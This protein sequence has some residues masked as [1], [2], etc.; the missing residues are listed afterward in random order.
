MEETDIKSFEDLF[1]GFKGR[2]IQYQARKFT[3]NL[4]NTIKG[5]GPKSNVSMN[6][7]FEGNSDGM[8]AVM[9]QVAL[10]AHFPNFNE[11]CRRH[12]SIY[13]IVL[14]TIKSEDHLK[15]SVS[16]LSGDECLGNLP[17]YCKLTFRFDDNEPFFIENE[18]SFLDI[19][20]EIIGL[21][22]YSFDKLFGN[23][24]RSEINLTSGEIIRTVLIRK[25]DLSKISLDSREEF[26]IDINVA[27][28]V[29]MIYKIGV[30]IDNLPAFD[31]TN[32]SMYN[33]AINVLKHRFSSKEIQ[34]YW[35][36][37]DSG[38]SNA[39][40]LEKV[41]KK[42]S[43]VSCADCLEQR[44]KDLKSEYDRD[45]EV[46]LDKMIKDNIE[47]LAKCE[48]ARWNV[49]EL[50]LGYRPLNPVELWEFSTKI[51]EERDI[52]RKR[53]RDTEK[54]HVDLCSCHDLRRI[55]PSDLRYD[56]F[57]ILAIPIIL[58]DRLPKLLV[59]HQ[60]KD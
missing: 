26:A 7:V 45:N 9:R 20:L 52:Y 14:D 23:L 27:K 13:T 29:N 32:Y 24:D 11:S 53:K 18:N 56:Y 50:V 51:G 44:I 22:E 59:S 57:L 42:L 15:E 16:L 48:H 21:C 1:E 33:I 3:S 10:R 17:K 60:F 38:H 12:R 30:D 49:E 37:L 19:E 35:D 34:K 41:A 8:K 43:N 5:I 54:A 58:S 4:F 31:F 40:P 25:S 2:E 39:S 28:R 55:N 36:E 46:A 6:F 47:I